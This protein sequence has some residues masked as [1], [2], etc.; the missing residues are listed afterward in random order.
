MPG[1]PSSWKDAYAYAANIV[2]ERV[3]RDKDAGVTK[4]LMIAANGGAML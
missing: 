1:C 2:N 3:E 4:H